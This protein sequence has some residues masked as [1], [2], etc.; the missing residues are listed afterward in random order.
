M[1]AGRRIGRRSCVAPL[2]R[3]TAVR[4]TPRMPKGNHSASG[5]ARVRAGVGS[6]SAV[7]GTTTLGD[8]PLPAVVVGLDALGLSIAARVL[9]HPE[10][11]LAGAVD[12]ARQGELLSAVLPGAPDVKVVGELAGVSR[13]A[14]GGVALVAAGAT[15]DEAMAHVEAAIRVGLHVVAAH[16]ELA[17]LAFVDEELAER[18]DR[19]ASRAGVAVLGTGVSPGLLLDRLVVTAASCCGEPRHVEAGRVIEAGGLP[20][21]RLE[22]WGLGIAA[23]A[24]ERRAEEGEAGDPGLSVACALLAD[25]LALEVDEIEEELV[26]IVAPDSGAE[27][28]EAGMVTGIRQ[29]ARAFDEGREVVR[30]ELRV[31]AG[32]KPGAYARID[33]EPKIVLEIPGGIADDP[34]RAWAMVNAAT[35]V[36][37]AEPGLLTVMDLPAG[38]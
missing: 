9:R 6:S 37:A 10:L 1:P 14:R 35:R 38:R 36:A 2:D 22:R 31:E 26:P 33:A 20:A 29:V 13:G 11:R 32:A 5:P 34:A 15:L 8:E 28:T 24:F 23:A 19:T 25:G 17:H 18:L 3:R 21:V 12:P 30:V 7:R 16:E 27:G 4:Y